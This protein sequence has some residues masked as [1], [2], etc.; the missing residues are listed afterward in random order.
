MINIGDKVEVTRLYGG[1]EANTNL[2]V[3]M[4]GKVI[5][6][7]KDVLFIEFPTDFKC[8]D[9]AYALQPDGTYMMYS[10]QVKSLEKMV[11][12][13][14][15]KK[16]VLTEAGY[17]HRNVMIGHT[18][19]KVGESLEGYEEKVCLLWIAFKWVEEV[20]IEVESDDD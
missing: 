10:H 20:D 9:N 18:S 1:D 14:P 2:H 17:E 13:A 11:Y 12:A 3:G 16:F 4:E 5:A 6:K 15:G 19:P 7:E 8:I